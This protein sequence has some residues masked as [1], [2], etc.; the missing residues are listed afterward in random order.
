[1]EPQFYTAEDIMQVLQ[2]K[3]TKAYSI[4]ND[5]NNELKEQGYMTIKGKVPATYFL[6][7]FYLSK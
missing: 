3:K 6:E 7:R 2:V 4:I 5:L 1:M